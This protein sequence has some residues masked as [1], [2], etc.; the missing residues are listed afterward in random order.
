MTQVEEKVVMFVGYRAQF[1]FPATDCHEIFPRGYTEIQWPSEEEVTVHAVYFHIT[2][3][4]SGKTVREG[5][6]VMSVSV[7]FEA[8]DVST[9]GKSHSNEGHRILAEA[10]AEKLPHQ[11]KILVHVH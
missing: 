9:V 11:N 4:E 7:A 3:R 8:F 6:G 10:I 1:G 5:Y 2:E